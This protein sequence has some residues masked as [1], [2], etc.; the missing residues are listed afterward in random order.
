[1]G[2]IYMFD[3]NTGRE[4]PD[5]VDTRKVEVL[6]G[7]IISDIHK[8]IENKSTMFCVFTHMN[9]CDF[10]VPT[11]A[12]AQK[13]KEILGFGNYD[14]KVINAPNSVWYTN[15]VDKNIIISDKVD[16]D[17]DKLSYLLAIYLNI[18]DKNGKTIPKPSE[19]YIVKNTR[20]SNIIEKTPDYN[21]AVLACDRSP[22]T[23][24]IKRSTNEVIYKSKYGK[25]AVPYTQKN[26]GTR[27][28]NRIGINIGV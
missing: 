7:S 13:L 20:N 4:L 17:K 8:L 11:I 24:I 6:L 16:L 25:V 15:K 23:I 2:K 9:D 18:I 26:A 27:F 14:Y 10:A 5:K 19:M 3:N 12:E 21:A 22:C 28:K 1:M